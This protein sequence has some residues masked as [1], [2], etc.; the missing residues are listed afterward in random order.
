MPINHTQLTNRILC[1]MRNENDLA[2][3]ITYEWAVYPPSLFYENGML[4]KTPKSKLAGVLPKPESCKENEVSMTSVIDGGFLL[5]RVVW[6]DKQSYQELYDTYISYVKRHYGEE[7]IIVFDGYG[8]QENSTK[9]L[10]QETSNGPAISRSSVQLCMVPTTS[11]KH[12]LS[13]YQN[14]ARSIDGLKTCMVENHGM[15]VLQGRDD[16]DNLIVQT[17]IQAS[18][19]NGRC[20]IVGTDTDILA[21]LI[22]KCTNQ[23]IHYHIPGTELNPNVTYSIKNTRDNMSYT[24]KKYIL[25]LHDISGCDT[26]SAL[27]R[28]GKKK[29]VKIIENKGDLHPFVDLFYNIN[30]HPEEI[31]EAGE[32]FLLQLYG[33]PEMIVSLDDLRY[34]RFQ[35][36]SKKSLQ[37][38]VNM[39]TLPPTSS[40][41]R[42]SF[43][44]YYQ[45]QQWLLP[46]TYEFTDVI[47]AS[48]WGWE[49]KNGMLSPIGSL[50]PVAPDELLK[51]MACGCK[52]GVWQGLFM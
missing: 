49:W 30:S 24:V 51:M 17:A 12:F 35:K 14:K 21:L 32:K 43:R 9:T 18:N 22:H 40:D 3:Y 10:E 37:S 6:P 33:A 4:R 28:Q 44:V 34:K 41:A 19:D 25:F 20:T 7:S 5:Y 29:A 31:A 47:N 15:H 48:N 2:R 8:D 23:E 13:N 52:K 27:F 42:H 11:Q 38:Q 1:M 36:A 46:A 26:T 16:A 39:A 45:I 50:K